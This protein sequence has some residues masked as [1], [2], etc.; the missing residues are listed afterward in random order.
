[1]FLELRNIEN[2]LS[3]DKIRAGDGFLF[4]TQ[5][6]QMDRICER[7]GR[8]TN[9]QRRPAARDLFA[10]L[11]L[12]LV[13]HF[14]EHAYELHGI[15]IVHILCARM[16]AQRLVIPGQTQHILNTVCGGAQNITLYRQP[17]SIAAGNLDNGLESFL[18]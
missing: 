11:E 3:L 2:K 15:E 9:K 8:S 17:V 14:L 16:I 7:I 4:Q 18:E 13:A 5:R 10:A 12:V 1:L 6:P